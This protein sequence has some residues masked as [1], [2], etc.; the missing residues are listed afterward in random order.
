MAINSGKGTVDYSV[1]I[2]EDKEDFVQQLLHKQLELWKFMCSIHSNGGILQ[3]Q[4][5][6]MEVVKKSVISQIF[7]LG[8]VE[9][10]KWFFIFL[11]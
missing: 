2:G 11:T 5:I 6:L 3:D 10:I 4:T 9:N 1:L 8:M 7:L